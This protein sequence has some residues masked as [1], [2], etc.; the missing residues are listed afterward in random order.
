MKFGHL[1][2]YNLRNV[3]AEKSYTKYA[4]EIIP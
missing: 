1:V 4:A 3:F 2:E